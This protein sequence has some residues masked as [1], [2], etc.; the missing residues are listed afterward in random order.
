MKVKPVLSLLSALFLS[1]C[2]NGVSLQQKSENNAGCL[3]C[4]SK[5]PH[6]AVA[7]TKPAI[8]ND[9]PVEYRV[10]IPETDPRTR[11]VNRV[12]L[13]ADVNITAYQGC[14]K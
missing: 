6:Y 11:S 9:Y 8:C 14:Q 5:A 13:P 3:D 10:Q 12:H 7:V 1:A 2:A 4:N